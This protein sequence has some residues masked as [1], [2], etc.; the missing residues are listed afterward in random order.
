LTEPRAEILGVESLTPGIADNHAQLVQVGTL[1][2]H[3]GDDPRR[4]G[5]GHPF[6]LG[7]VPRSPPPDLEGDV[8]TAQAPRSLDGKDVTLRGKT[9]QAEDFECRA[10][11]DE[12]I[13]VDEALSG[14]VLGIEQE[15]G[16]V[17]RLVGVPRACREAISTAFRRD[18]AAV[19]DGPVERDIGDEGPGLGAGDVAFLSVGDLG[20]VSEPMIHPVS[21]T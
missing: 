4:A 11:E 7:P 3:L 1:A 10:A 9:P 2:D 5:D 16:G 18:E 15:P 17:Q 12:G 8:A 14:R 20:Q 13:G 6:Y 21:V 19:V